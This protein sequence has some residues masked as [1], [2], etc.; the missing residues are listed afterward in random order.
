[1]KSSHPLVSICIPTFNRINFL[2]E[3]IQSAQNQTYQNIEIIISDN[4]QD[5]ITL[6]Y[7]KTIKDNR[8][9]YNKNSKNIGSF[10]NH[11]KVAS[12]A[13]GKYIKFLSDDDLLK[14]TCVEKMVRILNTNPEIGVVMAPL[15]IID[16]KGKPTIPTFYLI[17]KMHNL[18]R[19]LDHNTPVKKEVIMKDFLTR[20]YPCCVPT[21][22]LFR[23]SL[24]DKI[25]G[26]DK[27]Y[28]YICDL[29]LCMNFATKMDF[30]YI[31]EFLSSWRYSDSSETMAIL[32]KKGTNQKLFYQ[33][34]KKYLNY[35]TVKQI[36]SLSENDR[37]KQEA[38]L[39]ASKRT[40]LNALAGIKSHNLK[41]IGNTI[42]TI[43]QSDPYLLNK[44]K[45]PGILLYE[46]I[47]PLFI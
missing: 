10:A 23:K 41:Q 18:Y 25:G 27:K 33:L 35:P 39:F 21:G 14:P 29:D 47:R 36:F 40:L 34:A 26:F 43:Y 16:K 4:N 6:N 19:Y 37:I 7:I 24:Y 5:K 28:R 9:R 38:Y 44:I 30:Y 22:I 11:K 42:K 13:K 2:K 12:L 3:A 15:D 46:I 8:I 1:M 17:R 31:D 32:H 20:I 45:L